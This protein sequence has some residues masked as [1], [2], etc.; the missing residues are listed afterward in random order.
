VKKIL[1]LNLIKKNWLVSGWMEVK[2]VLRNCL[3]QY[4]NKCQNEH[5]INGC[6]ISSLVGISVLKSYQKT[7]EVVIH[8]TGDAN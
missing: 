3:T 8:V 1:K 7:S 2:A 4:K 5:Q 6:V